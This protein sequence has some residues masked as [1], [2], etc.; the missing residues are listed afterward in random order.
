MSCWKVLFVSEYR[1]KTNYHHEF[2]LEIFDNLKRFCSEKKLK[3]GV[4]YNSLRPDKSLKIKN[5]I[6]F[7]K[8]HNLDV[9]LSNS[10]QKASAADTVLVMH[11]NLG[12]EL[13]SHKY[14]VIFFSLIKFPFFQMLH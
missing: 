4:A 3:I 10:Y 5:E 13:I 2:Q 6:S 1:N 7:L 12:L 9:D 14:K 11:S 8:S